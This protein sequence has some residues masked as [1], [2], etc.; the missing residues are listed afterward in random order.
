MRLRLRPQ[1]RTRA[2]RASIAMMECVRLIIGGDGDRDREREGERGK[3]SVD[4]LIHSQFTVAPV[5]K[6]RTSNDSNSTSNFK[7][8]LERAFQDQ[9]RHFSRAAQC[10]ISTLSINPL[11]SA[12]SAPTEKLIWVSLLSCGFRKWSIRYYPHLLF[13]AW[14]G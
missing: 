3:R 7:R 4:R 14:V 5:T 8:L 1:W 12:T 11:D 9:T 6:T 10:S 2:S 13:V